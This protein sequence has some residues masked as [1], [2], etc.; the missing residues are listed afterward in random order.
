MEVGGGDPVEISQSLFLERNGWTGILVEPQSRNCEL[1]RKERP[2][3]RL[4]QVACGS[5]K[6][7]GKARLQLAGHTSKLIP[8]SLDVSTVRYED[9]EV[10]TLD[11]VLER[12][13]NPKIDFVSID[14]EGNDL[15][16]LRGFDLKRHRP[17]LILIEDD[18]HTRLEIYKY[19]KGQGYRLVKRSGSN[20]WYVPKD[21]PFTLTTG[22]EK[23]K[24]FRKMFLATPVRKLKARL[25]GEKKR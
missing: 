10:I 14:V 3:V 16:V 21:Q 12:A 18:I 13:G 9:V 6:Q 4:F 11:E 25:A 5:P 7:R 22:W 19:L 24:L 15:E 8:D 1:I 2:G 20:N 17:Q 23:I